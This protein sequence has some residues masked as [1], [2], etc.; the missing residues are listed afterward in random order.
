MDGVGASVEM[1][2][3]TTLPLRCFGD[4]CFFKELIKE[5]PLQKLAALG[6][7]DHLL[8]TDR[9]LNVRAFSKLSVS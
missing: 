6:G 5:T 7:A 8:V 9:D 1:V 3:P 2:L 4:L